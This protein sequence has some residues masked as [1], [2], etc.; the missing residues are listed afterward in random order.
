MSR[1]TP[2]FFVFLGPTLI[3]KLVFEYADPVKESKLNK[4]VLNP[5]LNPPN[6]AK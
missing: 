6:H 5:S 2:A 3:F 4:R 1:I